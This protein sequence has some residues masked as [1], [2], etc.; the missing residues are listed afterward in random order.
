MEIKKPNGS[1]GHEWRP[2]H[3]G[4]ACR[5]SHSRTMTTAEDNAVANVVITIQLFINPE[6][7]IKAG[8]KIEVTQN[9]RKQVYKRSG[10][11]AVY[12]THQ[13]IVLALVGDR[14]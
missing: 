2:V 5:L 12:P 6:I 9:G 4:L 7:L 13:E 3:E 1:T 10:E 11:P 14:A 8:S